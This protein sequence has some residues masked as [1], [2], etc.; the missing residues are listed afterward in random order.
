[1]SQLQLNLKKRHKVMSVS[2]DVGNRCALLVRRLIGIATVEDS[3]D[4]LEEL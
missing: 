4:I 2:E 1:M 3:L